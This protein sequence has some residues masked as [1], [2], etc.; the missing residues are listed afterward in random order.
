MLE[1]ISPI[2]GTFNNSEKFHPSPQRIKAPT[3]HN[4]EATIAFHFGLSLTIKNKEIG[5]AMT[6]KDS[7]KVL[8]LAEV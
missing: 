5:V 7:K 8:L 4:N 1:K 3:K 2:D 6:E